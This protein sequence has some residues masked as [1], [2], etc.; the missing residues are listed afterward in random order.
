MPAFD[1]T[2]LRPVWIVGVRMAPRP[3]PPPA[4]FDVSSPDRLQWN[5]GSS[6][7]SQLV[8]RFGPQLGHIGNNLRFHELSNH[9]VSHH[10]RRR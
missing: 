8:S 10:T 2:G 6:G 1:S 4:A 7:D 3:N 5:V 9:W